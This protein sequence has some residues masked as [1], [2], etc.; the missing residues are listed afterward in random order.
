MH[1]TKLNDSCKLEADSA[2]IKQKMATMLLGSGLGAEAM[3]IPLIELAFEIAP[4]DKYLDNVIEDAWA[5]R[6]KKLMRSSGK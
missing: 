6:Y 2:T 1:D 3:T 5:L 4:N